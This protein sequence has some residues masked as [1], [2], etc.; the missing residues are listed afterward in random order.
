MNAR[1][2]LNTDRRHVEQGLSWESGNDAGTVVCRRAS[3]VP[4]IVVL[5]GVTY[6]LDLWR[7]WQPYHA[8]AACVSLPGC[9]CASG[10]SKLEAD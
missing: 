4:W 3:C 10:S 6:S 5:P 9:P 7:I 2:E 8:N 1:R